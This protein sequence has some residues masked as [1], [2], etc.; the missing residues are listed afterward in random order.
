[1]DNINVEKIIILENG[2][3]KIESINSEFEGLDDAVEY[4]LAY[5]V[6]N[7][8]DN[9][10]KVE[11]NLYEGDYPHTVIFSKFKD[12]WYGSEYLFNLKGYYINDLLFSIDGNE[13]DIANYLYKNIEK[14]NSECNLKLDIE[15]FKSK[16]EPDD[17]IIEE[18]IDKMNT[19]EARFEFLDA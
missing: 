13:I 18:L 12:K 2:N 17:F 15:S 4:F 14:I 6:S 11:F 5:D 10:K 7:F 19:S 8:P 9:A 3:K 16:I 1:M